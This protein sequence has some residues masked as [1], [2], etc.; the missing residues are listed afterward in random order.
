MLDSQ[1]LASLLERKR[2][3]LEQLHA[4]GQEQLAT[5]ESEDL[6]GLFRLLDARQKWL[7][8]FQRIEQALQPYHQQDPAERRWTSEAQREQCR[9]DQQRCQTLLAEIAKTE[10]RGRQ[11][12][13]TQR[14][15]TAQQL[16]TLSGDRVAMTGYGS[17]M[18]SAATGLHLDLSAES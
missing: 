1:L 7:D 16:Q 3:C 17:S 11:Q 6:D 5:I 15:R 13:E 10:E 12:L 2:H 9:A 18:S 4:L 14:A 8:A